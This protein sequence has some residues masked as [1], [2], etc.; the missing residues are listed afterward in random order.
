MPGAKKKEDTEMNAAK[1]EIKEEELDYWTCDECGKIFKKK[2]FIY[3]Y[4]YHVQ[5]HVIV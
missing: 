2:L 5:N 4:I 1:E 3:V